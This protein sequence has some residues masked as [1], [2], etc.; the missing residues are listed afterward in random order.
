MT[1]SKKLRKTRITQDFRYKEPEEIGD[2][3]SVGAYLF[4]QSH[5]TSQSVSLFKS[6]ISLTYLQF[7]ALLLFSTPSFV[8]HTHTQPP[9]LSHKHTH[10]HTAFLS[11]TSS[12]HTLIHPPSSVAHTHLFTFLLLPPHQTHSHTTSPNTHS[13]TL[14]LFPPEVCRFVPQLH[15]SSLTPFPSTLH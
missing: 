5:S 12:A 4:T 9:S 1:V 11:P 10:I 15:Y 8:A 2:S 6:P 13:T 3:D 7:T 14:S